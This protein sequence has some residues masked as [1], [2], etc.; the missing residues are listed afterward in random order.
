MKF[1]YTV[2]VSLLVL[3][4]IT[5]SLKNTAP[6]PLEYY[7]VI[8]TSVATYLLIF[9]SFFVG[10]I[11]VGL[12]DIMERFRLIRT[13][14]RLNKKVKELEK[15][16]SSSKSLLVAEETEPSDRPSEETSI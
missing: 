11:L 12:L 1:I 14:R 5:F 4:V 6:V 7:G 13:V 15:K 10:A 8:N 16:L 2:I 3:F 9:I